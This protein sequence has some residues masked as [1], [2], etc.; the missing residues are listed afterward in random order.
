MICR[1]RG[2]TWSNFSSIKL[3]LTD[4][5]P[6][7]QVAKQSGRSAHLDSGLCVSFCIH[8]AKPVPGMLTSCKKPSC[9]VF[10]LVKRG[11][12]Q[13]FPARN[14]VV[15]GRNY[16][17]F[18]AASRVNHLVQNSGVPAYQMAYLHRSTFE[19]APLSSHIPPI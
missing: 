12:L 8:A 7:A 4:T 2:P 11:L 9:A 17:Q 18:C 15:P 13:C 5:A 16:R 19:A 1:S 3:H 14:T 6:I 10:I